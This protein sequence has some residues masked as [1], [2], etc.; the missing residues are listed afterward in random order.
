[1]KNVQIVYDSLFDDV[2]VITIPDDIYEEIDRLA[3]EFFGLE[4]SGG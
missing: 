1:M 2:D 3:E 4:S